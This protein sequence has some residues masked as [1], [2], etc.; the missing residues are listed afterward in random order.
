[1][2]LLPGRG[3]GATGRVSIGGVVLPVSDVKPGLPAGTAVDVGIRPEEVEFAGPDPAGLSLAVD[4]VEELGATQ[5]FYGTLG[6]ASF[7][8][9][10]PTGDI[11]HDVKFLAL[12]VT[13]DRLHVFDPQS[14]DRL[15]REATVKA[16]AA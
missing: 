12:R 8:L 7:V 13:P 14:G 5:L 15:G 9:Q 4:F 2:N 11:G 1:M 16:E 3:R 10:A 6:G